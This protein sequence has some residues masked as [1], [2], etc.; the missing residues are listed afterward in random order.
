MRY[1]FSQLFEVMF[2]PP[3]IFILLLVLSILWVKNLKTLKILLALQITL[4]YF[5]CIPL[6]S[7]V[8][9]SKLETL[10]ALNENQ[11]INNKVDA[12]VVLAGGIRAFKKEYHGPDIGYFT[13]VRL[14]YAAWLQKQ[15]GLPVIVTGGVERDGVSEAELMKQVLQEE[16]EITVPIWIEKQSKNTY[17]NAL[18]SSKI[19]D[20]KGYQ[21]Y[22]L[23][24]SAF[25]MSRAL[26]AFKEFNE[27]IIPA[28]AAF[29]YNQTAFE[30]GKLKP[31]SHA[32]WNNYLALHEIFGRYLYQ[33][34]YDLQAT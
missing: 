5:L 30:L 26:D 2:L 15:T 16:Y 32:L 17:E 29:Y 28:P 19:L 10:P 31:Q 24:T 4:I 21:K 22:Y 13:L 23:V 7:D 27:N 12:I 9:F 14:R 11:I 18:Y 25:H 6:T 3:G 8:L 34:Y 20:E 1:F 33:I